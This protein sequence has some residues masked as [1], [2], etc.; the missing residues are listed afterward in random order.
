VNVRVGRQPPFFFRLAMRFL[1]AG[2]PSRT[3]RFRPFVTGSRHVFPR[4]RPV[5]AAFFPHVALFPCG[6]AMGSGTSSLR[7]LPEQ[8]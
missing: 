2:S 5:P 7:Q 3:L 1:A 4:S 8:P 6:L